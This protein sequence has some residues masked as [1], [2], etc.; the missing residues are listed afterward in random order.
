VIVE[1]FAGP[2]G[3]GEGA[4]RAGSRDRIVGLEIDAAACATAEAAGHERIQADVRTYPITEFTG[5]DGVIASPVC[6]TFAKPG[7]RAGLADPRGQLVWEAQRWALGLHPRW[8]AFEQVPEVLPIWQIIAAELRQA[9][10]SVWTGLVNSADHGVPQDR[11]RAALIGRLDGQAKPPEPTHAADAAGDLF[12]SQL[13]QWETIA[14]ALPHREDW[15]Y[16]RTRGAGISA[17]HGERP[18]T[19]ASRP[20][21]T[22]TG[23]ARSDTWVRDGQAERVT[24]EEAAVLQSF[25][26]DY[27][28][29]GSRSSAFQ[30]A[31]NAIPPLLAAAIL[32]PL[33]S[34]PAWVPAHDA[35]QFEGR[36]AS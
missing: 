14:T 30:Q 18:D 29:Q 3:W 35:A 15:S 32:R 12:G 16:R 24:L 2:G 31:G 27:P 5:A 21:P 4:R 19:P 1:L 7:N 6:T 9:G 22:I 11:R 26:V 34:E 8:V 10:Y 25:P 33:I 13:E 23:K 28:W 20:A 36:V 17:R